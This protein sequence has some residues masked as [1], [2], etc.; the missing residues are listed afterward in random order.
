MARKSKAQRKERRK[1][2]LTKVRKGGKLI[3]KVG[4]VPTRA[5]FIS[6]VSLNLFNLATR[7]TQ[8][9]AKNPNAVTKFWENFGGDMKKLNKAIIKGLSV[10][11]K[12]EE[13]KAKKRGSVSG[14]DAEIGSVTAGAVIAIALPIVTAVL[15]LFSANKS[16][17]AGDNKHD[18]ENVKT[19]KKTLI[20]NSPDKI[21]DSASGEEAEV[22]GIMDNKP[23]LIGG[24]FA[25]AV[26]GYFL[27]HK[28][29]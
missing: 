26:A 24:A 15:K 16:D 11:R 27:L 17:K 19:L 22:N 21:L 29:K 4:M 10:K 1:K 12:K 20:E 18:K 13:R 3:M 7:L 2:I 28:K 14:H 9:A 8:L 25:L 23:L 6:A 5:A